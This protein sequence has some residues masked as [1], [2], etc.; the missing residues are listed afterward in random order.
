M[1]TMK[2]TQL[3]LAFIAAGALMTSCAGETAHEGEETTTETSEEVAV[4]SD[5][6]WVIDT[7]KST[8]T[9]EGGTAGEQVYAH[10]G[11]LKIKEGKITSADNMVTG[12]L[13]IVDMSSINPTDENYSEEHPASDLVGHLSSPDFFDVANNPTATFAIKEA[14]GNDIH[15]TMTIRGTSNEEHIQFDMINFTPEGEMTGEGMMEFNRQNYGVAWKHY[16]K[17]VILA[18]GIQLRFNIVAKKA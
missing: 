6:E 13:I 1:K 14:H 9:W 16:L 3:F 2:K 12:G 10:T 4:S 5:G 17:D 18:D 8:I 15:G 7:E 11:T